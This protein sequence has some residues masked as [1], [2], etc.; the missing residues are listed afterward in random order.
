MAL[1]VGV[2]VRAAVGRVPAP[3]MDDDDNDLLVDDNDLIFDV[4]V[5]VK[6]G[7]NV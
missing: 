2:T 4:A 1:A 7:A 6:H 3:I 5:W